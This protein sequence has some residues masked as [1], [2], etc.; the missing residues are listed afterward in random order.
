[1][2]SRPLPRKKKKKKKSDSQKTFHLIEIFF[3]LL[4][5]ILLKILYQIYLLLFLSYPNCPTTFVLPLL[6][7]LLS[8]LQYNINN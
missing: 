7:T 5:C 2:H 4:T 6:C 1:M 8:E 3:F